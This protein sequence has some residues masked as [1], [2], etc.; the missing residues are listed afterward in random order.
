MDII[1]TEMGK[2]KKKK[3]RERES[4]R[5]REKVYRVLKTSNFFKMYCKEDSHKRG[6]YDIYYL[7]AIYR[8]AS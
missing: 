4:L 5:G 2:R 1:L 6:L 7:T 3:K 8:K